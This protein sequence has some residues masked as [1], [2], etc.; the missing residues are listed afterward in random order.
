MNEMR[1]ILTALI[2][3]SP[4]LIWLWVYDVE[5][6]F[7]AVAAFVGIVLYLV[8]SN[9]FSIYEMLKEIKDELKT[10]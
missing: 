3:L 9:L 5:P 8:M 6:K 4:P 7:E 2:C 1:N 10:N